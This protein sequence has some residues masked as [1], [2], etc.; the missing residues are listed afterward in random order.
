[1][2]SPERIW[3]YYQR[4]KY[5]QAST[6]KADGEVEYTRSDLVI[7][8]PDDLVARVAA[9]PDNSFSLVANAEYSDP[10]LLDDVLRWLRHIESIRGE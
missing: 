9:L 1:M 3:V 6:I 2:S 4:D 8:K 7:P 10:R 5:L